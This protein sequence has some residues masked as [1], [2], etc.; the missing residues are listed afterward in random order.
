MRLATRSVLSLVLVLVAVGPANAPGAVTI[1]PSFTILEVKGSAGPDRISVDCE[2]GKLTVN[3][4]RA[5]SG[6]VPCE[7]LDELTVDGLGG[8]D[9][10]RL[11]LTEADSDLPPQFASFNGADVSITAGDGDDD[12]VV[13]SL[14]SGLVSAGAGDDRILTTGTSIPQVSGGPGDDRIR[15]TPD[16]LGRERRFF[17]RGSFF[18][19][20]GEDTLL[21]GSGMDALFGGKGAD[22]LVGRARFDLLEGGAGDDQLIGGLGRDGLSGGSG[23][24]RLSGEE[25]TDIVLGRSGDDLLS[26]GPAHDRLYGGSGSDR[27][28]GGPGVDVV[29]QK[30]LPPS[31]RR[32]PLAIFVQLEDRID[33]IIENLTNG[34]TDVSALL[35]RSHRQAR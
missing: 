3:G 30:G 27:L 19:G 8:K 9:K 21:G 6:R 28:R 20:A 13:R 10:I 33:E 25:G 29:E 18:G 12:I 16:D 26:G 34:R 4:R 1:T 31:L 24:D 14:S 11:D 35:Q 15:S 2:N 7:K 17:I 32:V 22:I 23:D 5:A